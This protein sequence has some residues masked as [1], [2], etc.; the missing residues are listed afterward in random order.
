MLI[1]YIKDILDTKLSKDM[2][3]NIYL[4]SQGVRYAILLE[5][6]NI[7]DKINIKTFY[8]QVLE[9]INFINIHLTEP[10]TIYEED[11]EPF[12]RILICKQKNY[13]NILYHLK[14]EPD[15]QFQLGRIL[16]MSYPG[17]DFYNFLV[18]RLGARIYVGLDDLFAETCVE[19]EGREKIIRENMDLKIEIYNSVL[20]KIGLE[21]YYE[22]KRDDGFNYRLEQIKNKNL[23]Y[24]AKNIKD[25]LNDLYNEFEYSKEE[26]ELIQQIVADL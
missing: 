26:V 21:C 3:I 4:V 10:L 15:Y 9:I 14:I 6:T 20:K 13:F 5:Y 23:E 24:I 16:E 2:I 17:N 8:Q 7:R 11:L 12:P 18:P 19:Q 25:Y 22:I 1:N